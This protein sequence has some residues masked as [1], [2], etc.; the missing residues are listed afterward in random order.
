M[1]EIIYRAESAQLCSVDPKVWDKL[2]RKFL[3]PAI[4]SKRKNKVVIRGYFKRHVVALSKCISKDRK[5]G[6]PIF[7]DTEKLK[8]LLKER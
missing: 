2:A 3:S 8:K 1:D 7:V 4:E 5:P 6:L